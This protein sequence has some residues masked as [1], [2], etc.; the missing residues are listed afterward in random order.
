VNKSNHL[1]AYCN[2]WLPR[3]AVC[4]LI[5]FLAAAATLKTA[6]II[7]LPLSHVA[8]LDVIAV[9]I[10]ALLAIGLA[11]GYYRRLCLISVA[12]LGV[13]FLIFNW[14]SLINGE[15]SCNCLGVIQTTPKI[16]IIIDLIMILFAIIARPL[17]KNIN[18]PTKPKL[19]PA[20]AHPSALVIGTVCSMV[21][22]YR[23]PPI[24]V[25]P[26]NTQTYE[27]GSTILVQPETWQANEKVPLLNLIQSDVPIN[28]G[29]IEVILIRAGCSAC[30]TKLQSIVDDNQD[31]DARYA[32]IAVDQHFVP[33][34]YR[35]ILA[36][37]QIRYTTGYLDPKFNWIV[38]TPSTWQMNNGILIAEQPPVIDK[39]VAK[40]P[41]KPNIKIESESILVTPKLVDLGYLE[42]NEQTTF[43]ITLTNHN[44]APINIRSIS[45]EC[46]CTQAITSVSSLAPNSST[47]IDFSFKALNERQHYRKG[48]NI[49]IEGLNEPLYFK[50]QAR[51]DLPFTTMP[52]AITWDHL[53]QED[54]SNQPKITFF[55]DGDQPVRLLY[56]ESNCP[57]LAAKVPREPIPAGQQGTIELVI[58]PDRLPKELSKHYHLTLHT[59]DPENPK[60]GIRITPRNTPP[61]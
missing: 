8:Q 52:T 6:H 49:L 45:P 11:S 34:K 25:N 32:I 54:A 47:T 22:A 13:V 5:L 38:S 18:S 9:L 21:I 60:H 37:A 46:I 23:T 16:M 61:E 10:E 48:V 35:K 36:D 42:P 19:W 27:R 57:G 29:N 1:F 40:N 33:E 14:V 7:Q 41:P 28:R 51:I 39:A 2:L 24:Y 3:L 12:L 15:T 4:V 44:D 55:N 30:N 58:Q 26:T 31:P 56:A 17:T 43:S 59:T 20:I 50:T 53:T